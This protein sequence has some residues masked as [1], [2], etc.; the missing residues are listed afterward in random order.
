M[1]KYCAG[2]ED[3]A[4]GEARACLF[5]RDGFGGPAQP[6][7][8]RC[9]LCCVEA[10]H[11]TLSSR[12]GKGNLQRLLKHWR[13]VK[14]PVYEAAFELGSLCALSV[15]EQ[16]L[17]R[18]KAGEESKLEKRSSWLHKKKQRWRQHWIYLQY[19]KQ[20]PFA[21]IKTN[22]KRCTYW[23]GKPAIVRGKRRAWWK[24]RRALKAKCLNSMA[25]G[26]PFYDASLKWAMEEGLLQAGTMVPLSTGIA[27]RH[28]PRWCFL[29]DAGDSLYFEGLEDRVDFQTQQLLSA[30][31]SINNALGKTEFLI[32]ASETSSLLTERGYDWYQHMLSYDQVIFSP[33]YISN[34]LAR[35]G[36]KLQLLRNDDKWPTT[37]KALLQIRGTRGRNHKEYW[38]ALRSFEGRIYLLDVFQPKPV[39]IENLPFSFTMYRTYAMIPLWD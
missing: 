12:V 23:S 27:Y 1:P 22:C 16:H 20:E 31:A 18:T 32:D 26:P 8:K 39:L 25:A 28:Q 34:M 38:A 13:C 19:R 30:E 29:T 10:L 2:F 9:V 33:L 4:G 36:L 37:A 15:S 6:T 17:L 35:I 14:S 11:R 3:P 24:V 7:G 5:A 21:N